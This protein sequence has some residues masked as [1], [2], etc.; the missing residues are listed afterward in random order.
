MKKY[1]SVSIKGV[2]ESAREFVEAWRH[3]KQRQPV[4][5]PIERLYFEELATMLKVLMPRRLEGTQGR[6]R[7]R[8]RERQGFGRENEARL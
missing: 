7:D 8:T 6:S 4:E 2:R 3:A 1:L 5:Q